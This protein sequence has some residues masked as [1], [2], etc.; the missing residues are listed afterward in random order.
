MYMSK[1]ILNL[2]E[3]GGATLTW[4]DEL[5]TWGIIELL[6]GYYIPVKLHGDMTIETWWID[7]HHMVAFHTFRQAEY[8]LLATEKNAYLPTEAIQRQKARHHEHINETE[9]P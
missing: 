2:G 7:D 6:H 1:H 9:N 4:N 5:P 8:F 3:S